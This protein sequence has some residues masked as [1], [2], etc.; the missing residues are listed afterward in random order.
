MYLNQNDPKV[1]H[2]DKVFSNSPK[3]DIEWYINIAV[4]SGDRCIDLAAGTGILTIALAKA[5]QNVLAIDNS[6]FMLNHLNNKLL[7]ENIKNR[8][9]ILNSP[10]SK[11][12]TNNVVDTVV[13]RDSFY[14]NLTPDSERDTFICVNKSLKHNGLFAFN[15]H[16]PGHKYLNSISDPNNLKYNSRGIYTISN[17]RIEILEFVELDTV[18]QIITTNLK[19]NTIDKDGITISTEYS[20]WKT[21][22]MYPYE[23]IYL[24]ELTGF[25]VVDIYG[26]YNNNPYSPES[27]LVFKAKKIKSIAN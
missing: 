13:C 20:Q 19:F 12:A 7:N 26:D 4:S 11:F 14:H 18:N 8:I 15:M 27:L 10:M 6:E 22:Y 23:I 3:G 24:L 5:G 2:Y 1:I 9:K 21:R 25:E 17:T 16:Y